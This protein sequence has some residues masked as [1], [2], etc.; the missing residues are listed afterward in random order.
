M[1]FHSSLLKASLTGVLILSR[2]IGD[3][4]DIK[5]IWAGLWPISRTFTAG[6]SNRLNPEDDGVS[7]NS[8][9]EPADLG[10]KF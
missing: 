3:R 10:V 4:C 7:E 5:T 2:L 9:I 6:S 1:K 8:I